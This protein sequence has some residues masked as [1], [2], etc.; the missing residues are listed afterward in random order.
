MSRICLLNFVPELS[1]G[2]KNHF[3]KSISKLI[4]GYISTFTW[5]TGFLSRH[6]WTGGTSVAETY[7]ANNILTDSET[8][9][10]EFAIH[11]WIEWYHKNLRKPVPVSILSLSKT[12][13]S[14]E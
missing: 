2:N 3:M 5:N 7:L 14:G 12:R 11:L 4:F 10:D 8:D 6:L 1:L 13:N 9:T